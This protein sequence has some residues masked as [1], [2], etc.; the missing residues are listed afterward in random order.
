MLA[1]AKF[2][3]L[4]AV[5]S[6]ALLMDYFIYGVVTTLADH[7]R[8]HATGEGQFGLLHGGYVVGVLTAAPL[9]GYLGA[10]IGLKRSMICGV[11]LSA[12]APGRSWGTRS[13]ACSARSAA[14]SCCS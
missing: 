10:R 3:P 11:A 12:A 8:G 9:F 2:W 1:H 7:S 13:A 4:M 6:F 5:V 14:T